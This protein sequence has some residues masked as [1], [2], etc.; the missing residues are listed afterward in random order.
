MGSKLSYNK[1]SMERAILVSLVLITIMTIGQLYSKNKRYEIPKPTPAP[2][3]EIPYTDQKKEESADIVV[4]I[5][6]EVNRP[7]IVRL[8]KG[9]RLYEAIEKAGGF[10]E[11]AES[12]KINLAQ[13]L[14]DGCQYVVPKSGEEMI[15]HKNDG[16][17]RSGQV[18]E[19]DG[20]VNINTATKE[21]LMQLNGIGEVLAQRIIK[22]RDKVGGFKQISDLLQVEGIGESKYQSIK[23]D[24]FC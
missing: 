6:G 19:N 1:K 9:S 7:S 20:K 13:V 12:E 8:P 10:T 16:T 11:Q 17:Q 22:H 24:I 15:I 3:G 2:T 21:E 14:V 23:E 5:V 18:S 4:H